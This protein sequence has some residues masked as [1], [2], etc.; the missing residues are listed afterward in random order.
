MEGDRRRAHELFRSVQRRKNLP[1]A[2]RRT[3]GTGQARARSAKIAAFPETTETPERWQSGWGMLAR[4]EIWF[5]L[6]G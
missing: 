5:S 3:K 1:H 6:N 4:L 2:V